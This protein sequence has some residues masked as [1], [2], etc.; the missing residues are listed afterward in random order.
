MIHLNRPSAE[1]KKAIETTRKICYDI[2]GIFVDC[3]DLWGQCGEINQRNE[4]FFW[5]N[6]RKTKC[7]SVWDA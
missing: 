4:G 3:T 2:K 1:T 7:I 6:C 5:P